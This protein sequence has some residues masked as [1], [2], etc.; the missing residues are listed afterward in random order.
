MVAVGFN[1]FRQCTQSSVCE[2]DHS[3]LVSTLMVHSVH[4][5]RSVVLQSGTVFQRKQLIMEELMMAQNTGCMLLESRLVGHP[6]ASL[7]LLNHN[8][9]CWPTQVAPA[10]IIVA[11]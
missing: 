4:D 6:L 9:Y 3:A 10:I 5:A 8:K 11:N 1:N 2:H 7:F